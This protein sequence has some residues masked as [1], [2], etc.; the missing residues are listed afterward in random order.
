MVLRKW[1]FDK[2]ICSKTLAVSQLLCTE[3]GKQPL[4]WLCWVSA[5][6]FWKASWRWSG[7]FVVVCFLSFLPDTAFLFKPSLHSTQT[8]SPFTDLERK[9][10]VSC[11]KHLIFV[12]RSLSVWFVTPCGFL[13]LY[14]VLLNKM[15]LGSNY[16]HLL[17]FIAIWVDFKKRWLKYKICRCWCRVA[18][19]QL[20]QN[21]SGR[22]KRTGS[23]WVLTVFVTAARRRDAVFHPVLP[24]I[25]AHVMSAGCGSDPEAEW[26]LLLLTGQWELSAQFASVWRTW[27]ASLQKHAARAWESGSSTLAKRQKWLKELWSSL[28]KDLFR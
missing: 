12:N 5:V 23:T 15:G 28:E 18:T 4:V 20:N 3:I 26:C 22:K 25:S 19:A 9:R 7:N 6:W 21:S 1:I 27:K 11:G 2:I 16:L 13:Y 17:N 10:K 24:S 14:N 8:L